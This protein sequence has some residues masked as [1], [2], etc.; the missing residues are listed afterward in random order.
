MANWSEL[1]QELVRKVAT[2]HIENVEDFEEIG[3][4][5]SDWRSATKDVNLCPSK[6]T[7]LPWLMLVDPPNSPHRRFYS[8]SKHMFQKINLPQ[9]DDDDDD[10]DDDD[11]VR[12]F[13]SK[14]WL[15]SLSMKN[16]NITLFDPAS[17][18][19]IKLPS[20]PL[21]MLWYGDW[22]DDSYLGHFSKFILSGIPSSCDDDFTV[23]MMFDGN[24]Q[25]AFWRP[26][27]QKWTKP[28]VD[29]DINWM[30]DTCFFYGEFYA[31]D[32]FGKVMAFG[33]Q[34]S[35]RQP[36]IV[37]DLID[38]GVLFKQTNGMFYLV[39]VE[40]KLLVV[41]R[42]HLLLDNHERNPENTNEVCWTI[43]F[44]VFEL[45]VDN[46]KLKSVEGVGNQAIFIGLNSTFSV[47][48]SSGKRGCK[49]NCIYFIDDNTE[50][51]QEDAV[52]MGGGIDMGIYS[53]DEGKLIERFY[54][55]PSQFCF[56]T[57]P[58]WVERRGNM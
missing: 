52:L 13:S 18:K 49:P 15:I 30:L 43:C 12:Y 24:Q 17:G 40:S 45:N 37:V 38:Q 9:H 54:E 23:A 36:R 26:G 48:A 47:E 31:I 4:V 2:Q 35:N 21:N 10:D 32:H 41:H 33:S 27:E 22:Y 3:K 5:C 44:E 29:F 8:L 34:I 51:F 56:T 11:H 46:G 58:I 42:H 6:N 14:G 28:V 1:P 20:V 7:Q 50:Y 19:L 16:R 53:L 25:L 55:G 39:Q 57:P